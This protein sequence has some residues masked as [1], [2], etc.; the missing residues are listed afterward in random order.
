MTA[1]AEGWSGH[2]FPFFGNKRPHIFYRLWKFLRSAFSRICPHNR[3]FFFII[4]H[5]FAFFIHTISAN[6]S[7]DY[8]SSSWFFQ[9]W[10]FMPKIIVSVL[11]IIQS[12][13]FKSEKLT[14]NFQG[15]K[16]IAFHLFDAVNFCHHIPMNAMLDSGFFLELKN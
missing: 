9:L 12:E 6:F 8:N 11:K 16:K 10:E 13:I 3:I 1:P 5:I 7:F 14:Q 4:P 2:F 15:R